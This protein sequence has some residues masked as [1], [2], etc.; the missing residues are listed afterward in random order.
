MVS[1]NFFS[2]FQ[3]NLTSP[4]T[5][6]SIMTHLLSFL[7]TTTISS[8]LA[9]SL[10][11]I[12][13]HNIP[14]NIQL[15]IFNNTFWNMFIL[16]FT[17][18]QVTFPTKLPVNYSCNVVMPSFALL[19]CKLTTLTMWDIIP[20]FLSHILLSGDWAIWYSSCVSHSLSGLPVFEPHTTWLPFQVSSQPFST[21]YICLSYLLFLVFLVQNVHRSFYFPT[22]LSFLSSKSVWMP[23]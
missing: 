12:L 10:C 1:L 22:I 18:F 15:F 19:L 8:F 4:G 21:S 23:Q 11:H 13:N 14:Q 20:F 17:S 2:A 7:F 16:F 5:P 6:I 9:W 3:L